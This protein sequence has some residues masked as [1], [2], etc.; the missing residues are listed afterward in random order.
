MRRQLV[1]NFN[2]HGD[3]HLALTLHNLFI[4]PVNG[5]LDAS[6]N[7]LFDWYRNSPRVGFRRAKTKPGN[8]FPQSAPQDKG[9]AHVQHTEHRRASQLAS[10]Q[11]AGQGMG[12]ELRRS[13]GQVLGQGHPPTCPPG[14]ELAQGMVEGKAHR[15]QTGKA[16]KM[17]NLQPVM[18]AGKEFPALTAMVGPQ[19]N[20]LL[21]FWGHVSQS[22]SSAS[23]IQ[24][25]RG[26]P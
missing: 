9:M 15:Q 19:H 22:L 24:E 25:L 5:N 20:S 3:W 8:A 7:N 23:K 26:K 11:S 12:N 16:K 4:W 6:L 21:I 13:S 17:E 2:T 14:R 18:G 10:G 1:R